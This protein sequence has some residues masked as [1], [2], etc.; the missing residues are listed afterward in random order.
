MSGQ[1]ITIF[2]V[3]SRYN[4]KICDTDIEYTNQKELV[5]EFLKK[6]LMLIPLNIILLK[7]HG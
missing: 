4:N 7:K 6:K 2:L 5:V 1:Q 3:V